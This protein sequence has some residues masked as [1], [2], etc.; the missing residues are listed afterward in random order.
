MAIFW[1]ILASLFISVANFFMRRSI[2]GGGTTKGFLVFQMLMA[3]WIAVLLGPVQSGRYEFHLP[4]AVF[5]ALAGVILGTML[6]Y[7]GR[8]LERGP[9][10]LTFSILNASTVVP[11]LVMAAL[12]G[13]S[14]GYPYTGSHAMG[15][16]LVLG[17]LFWAGRGGMEMQEKKKWLLFTLAVFSLHS[18]L[19][20]LFQ[21][22]A[23]LLGQERP[24]EM[25]SFFNKEAIQSAWFA[26]FM[27]L[28]SFVLQVFFFVRG[29]KRLP[30]PQEVAY[31]LIGGVANGFCTYFM[32]LAT[33]V[34]NPLENAILFPVFSVAT[35][36]LSNFWGQRLYQ[37]KVN[38]R[39]C[40]LSAVG[41]IV[42]TVDWRSLMNLSL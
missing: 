4:L 35:I 36:F 38:W 29:E 10:G 16:L 2:D 14:L 22:R 42:G 32:I 6:Y 15:S 13:A 8:A 7:L 17:G 25:L 23:L 1:M 11:G 33:E 37:E 5:G 39:A 19:L 28:A 9:P 26:P 3:F 27:F 12:F 34:A 21:Y 41:L 31:G 30:H 20:I 40:Q 18:I 24:E